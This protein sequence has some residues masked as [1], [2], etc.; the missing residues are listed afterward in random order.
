MKTYEK[1]CGIMGHTD[2]LTACV[3]DVILTLAG[4]QKTIRV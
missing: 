2:T 1:E 3:H 4:V